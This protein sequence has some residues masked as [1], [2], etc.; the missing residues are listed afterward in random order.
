[1]ID[2]TL[3]MQDSSCWLSRS[4]RISCTRSN[5]GNLGRSRSY[6]GSYFTFCSTWYS[7]YWPSKYIYKISL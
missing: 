5:E 2:G 4:W 3:S 1:M 6:C 7:S